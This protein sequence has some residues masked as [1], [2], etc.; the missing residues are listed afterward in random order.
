MTVL[1]TNKGIKEYV[2]LREGLDLSRKLLRLAEIHL[3]LKKRG[4][5]ID[6]SK[7]GVEQNSMQ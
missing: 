7:R 4:L 5:L 1:Y 6:T 2:L 3:L